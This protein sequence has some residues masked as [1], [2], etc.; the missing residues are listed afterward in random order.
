MEKAIYGPLVRVYPK[1]KPLAR[2]LIEAA[3][4]QGAGEK[5]IEVACELA[6]GA[7]KEAVAARRPSVAQ[8]KSEMEAALESL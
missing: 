3:A 4:E 8:L 1:A 6:L 7:Y 5:E 2:A